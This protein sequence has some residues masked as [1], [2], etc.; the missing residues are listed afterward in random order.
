MTMASA[1]KPRN[2]RSSKAK[3][4]A[5]ERELAEYLQFRTG[6]KARRALLS[7]G[8]RNE[9]G[10][11]LDNTPLL[12]VEAKRTETLRPRAALEQAKTAV[13]KSGEPVIPV[14]ITRQNHMATGDSLVI[15]KLDDFLAF[16]TCALYGH[17]AERAN[18]KKAP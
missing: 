12:H 2:G 10:A 1:K 16:Y 18:G 9:G 8:G 13:L 4:S 15:L 3:G 5:Y 11:D 6:I 17:E 14:V 7:G